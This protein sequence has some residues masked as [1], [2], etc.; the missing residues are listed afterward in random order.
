MRKQLRNIIISLC[1]VAVLV[2]GIVSVNIFVK[3]KS[4]DASSFLSTSSTASI[5]VFKTDFSKITSVHVKNAKGEYTIRQSNGKYTVDGINVTLNKTNLAS[6]VSAV[7]SVK[8]I[9]VIDKNAK[10][11]NLYGLQN[12]EA[13]ID[14][15][16]GGVTKTINIGKTTPLADGC[17]MSLKGSNEVYKAATAF[18]TTFTGAALDFVDTTILNI[19]ES[20]MSDLTSIVFG[21][22]ARPNKI[23]LEAE[24]TKLSSSSSSS[25]SSSIPLYQMTSP[26][27]YAL[28]TQNMNTLTSSFQSLSASNAISL[29]V[30][31]ANLKK[32]G[33]DKPQ[34]SLS[35]TYSGKNT[36]ID[37]GTPYED[38]S[39]T[40]LPV[41]VEGSSVIYRIDSSKAAFYNW[42][43]KD[44]CSS[45]LFAE[46]ISAVKSVT[47]TS[48]SESYTINFSGT[49]N[50]ITA[51]C[52]SKKLTS[53]NANNFYQT[54]TNMSS[55]GQLTTPASGSAY[56]NIKVT[57][58]DASKAPLSMDFITMGSRQCA[59]AING[60]SDFYVLKDKVDNLLQ[61]TRNFAAGKAVSAP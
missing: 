9:K 60:K 61:V 13:V 36:T 59:W 54:L 33:L 42:Q 1:V 5:Q 43:L 46:E 44:I 21:G 58:N 25:N 2:I 32:Y 18:S 10:D 40:Y 49:N 22:T 27:G 3:P 29:D 56:V 31:S 6:A 16:S 7:S 55:E 15:T 8:A 38:G 51:T 35:Y 24:K 19:D 4:T 23:V 45:N 47:V 14:V 12:P 28:N 11:L 53:D 57:F 52:G 30:S 20:K 37:F 17:Y 39:T 50:N 41:M 34:Y 26:A 48:G